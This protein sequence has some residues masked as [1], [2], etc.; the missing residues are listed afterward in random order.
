MSLSFLMT[1]HPSI[2]ICTKCSCACMYRSRR[3]G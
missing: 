3:N 2:L 1:F